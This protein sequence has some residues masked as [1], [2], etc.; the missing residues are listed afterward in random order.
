MRL[1]T[2]QMIERAIVLGIEDDQIQKLHDLY[3]FD[4]TDSFVK[5]YVTWDDARFMQEFCNGGNTKCAS[6]LARLHDRNLLKRVF[7]VAT[8]DFPGEVRDILDDHLVS[9]EYAGLRKDLEGRI[10][11]KL[12]EETGNEADADLVILNAFTIRSVREMSRNDESGVL[13]IGEDEPRP[14]SEVSKLFASID[15]R[16]ADAAVEVYAPI[17]W[18]SVTHKKQLQ[19][20]LK[21]PITEAIA[22]GCIQHLK[23][24]TN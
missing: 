24:E 14:F 18:D 9:P 4:N 21:G 7:S 17:K 1:I 5:R 3:A 13:V 6:M 16:Y 12:S 8:T 19:R 10:A 2:D 15:G 23:G 20:Q 22:E 11:E